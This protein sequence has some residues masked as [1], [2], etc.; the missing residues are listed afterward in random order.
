MKQVNIGALM[1]MTVLAAL[2]GSASYAQDLTDAATDET[3]V[4]QSTV[5][6]N[7]TEET[8]SADE[9]SDET[10]DVGMDDG[11]DVT[12]DVVS[13]GEY[14]NT[15]GEDEVIV[16]DDGAI[17][18][19]WPID[20]GGMIVID[21]IEYCDEAGCYVALP[22]E[23]YP[24]LVEEG[25]DWIKREDDIGDLSE[26]TDDVCVVADVPV[27]VGMIEN[28][29]I[30]YSVTGGGAGPDMTGGADPVTLEMASSGSGQLAAVTG[31][32]AA[33]AT[34]TEISRSAAADGRVL[35]LSVPKA[36]R[37]DLSAFD[38]CEP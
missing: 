13:P 27:D 26:C 3:T 7:V 19:I 4:E 24:V 23:I 8:T 34:G 33:D 38:L 16:I 29:E 12:E 5:E 20:D 36:A 2:L 21:P 37:N 18:E 35:C 11:S 14:E 1:R 6:E 28:P 31:V 25:D 17:I 9:G 22:M 15:E 30:L 32:I 10:S